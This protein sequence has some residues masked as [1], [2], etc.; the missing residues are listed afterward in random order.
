MQ[1]SSLTYNLGTKEMSNEKITIYNFY[2]FI[3]IKYIVSF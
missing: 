3:P 1:W 2:I